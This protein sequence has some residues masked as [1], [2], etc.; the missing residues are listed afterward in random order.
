LTGFIT[1]ADKIGD[2]ADSSVTEL[3]ANANEDWT[4]RPKHGWWPL[5]LK[6]A[7]EHAEKLSDSM[8]DV[9][10]RA[11][12]ATDEWVKV[13]QDCGRTFGFEETREKVYGVFADMVETK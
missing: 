9:I 12:F 10:S 3:I 7:K 2:V 5:R 1:Q 13:Q 4:W 8:L 11:F 6:S